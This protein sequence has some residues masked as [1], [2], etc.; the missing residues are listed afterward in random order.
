M[1]TIKV[2][3]SLQLS[4]DQECTQ[5]LINHIVDC[6][7]A[8]RDVVSKQTRSDEDKMSLPAKSYGLFMSKLFTNALGKAVT[9]ILT[10]DMTAVESSSITNANGNKDAIEGYHQ[11]CEHILDAMPQFMQ[12]KSSSTKL[13]IHHAA[14]RHAA[15]DMEEV[16]NAE[17]ENCLTS[18][19]FEIMLRAHPEAAKELDNMG[20]TP[21]HWATRNKKVTKNALSTL[22]QAF[23]D[24]V[25][26]KDNSGYLPLHWAVSQDDPSLM[27]VNALIEAFPEAVSIRCQDGTIPLHWCVSRKSPSIEVL[28]AL[29]TANKTGA[30][31]IDNTGCTALHKCVNREEA[32]LEAARLLISAC[33]EALEV[34]D[35]EGHLAL[36]LAI[37]HDKPSTDV[38]KLLLSANPAGAAVLDKHGHLPLHCLVDNPHPDFLLAELVLEAYPKAAETQTVE[39]MYPVHIIVNVCEEPSPHFVSEL[40]N[41]Y[42]L[43]VRHEVI[44]SV[45]VDPH[46]NIHTWNGDWKEIRWTPFGRATERNLFTIIPV[47]RSAR[48]KAICKS[49]ADGDEGGVR[50]TVGGGLRGTSLSPERPGSPSRRS[51]PSPDRL[52]KALESPTGLRSDLGNPNRLPDSPKVAGAGGSS[53]SFNFEYTADQEKRGRVLAPIT[54]ASEPDTL[55]RG[56]QAVSKQP[57]LKEAASKYKV[58][59]SSKLSGKLSP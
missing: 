3:D 14:F 23:P 48:F 32:S 20:A 11:I 50:K 6:I 13:L 46:A 16:V 38:V 56:Q 10:T 57:P 15:T 37:D 1:S 5:P 51:S 19:S 30:R 41:L 47:L 24:A 17:T 49:S 25:R 28:Q 52:G 45:P 54:R 44:D 26:T 29:L 43:A 4:P 34:L 22:I 39:G 33:P 59:D 40:L 7:A 53:P 12:T 27:V 36:H 55:G 9:Q 18:K 58:G 21:L 2:L 8:L 42:P 31:S 35:N